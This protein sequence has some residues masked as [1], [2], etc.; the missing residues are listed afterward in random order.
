MIERFPYYFVFFNN[1]LKINLL[2][3]VNDYFEIIVQVRFANKTHLINRTLCKL[4]EKWFIG[5]RKERGIINRA[6]RIKLS[7]LDCFGTKNYFVKI[8]YRWIFSK[9]RDIYFVV[10][11]EGTS[12]QNLYRE[13]EQYHPD[14]T[15]AHI[16]LFHL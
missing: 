5:Q 11:I 15:L 3:T 7:R 16:I 12:Q 1:H 4:V 2:W 13:R 6:C 8:T 14:I 9:R 10:S